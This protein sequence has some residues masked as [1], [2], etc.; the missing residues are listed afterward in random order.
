MNYTTSHARTNLNQP[1]ISELIFNNQ[2]TSYQIGYTSINEIEKELTSTGVY[3]QDKDHR[4]YL[5]DFYQD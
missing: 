3:L 1:D 5:N 4:S 2:F